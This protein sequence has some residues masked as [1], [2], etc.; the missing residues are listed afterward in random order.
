MVIDAQNSLLCI[1]LDGLSNVFL[2]YALLSVVAF[3]EQFTMNCNAKASSTA[4]QLL[5]TMTQSEFIAAT[6]LPKSIFLLTLPLDKNLEE[7]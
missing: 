7:D 2:F 3:L 5:H 1:R 4:S 6:C